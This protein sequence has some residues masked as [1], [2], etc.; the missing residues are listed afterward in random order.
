MPLSIHLARSL[1]GVLDEPALIIEESRTIAAN[2]AARTLLGRHIEGTDVRFAIRHPEAL[3]TI[4]A[5]ETADLE[6]VG[7]GSADR[8][9]LLTV[10]PIDSGMTVVRLIDQSAGRAAER[11]RD[12]RRELPGS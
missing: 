1:I 11:M 4:L 3:R 7:I 9:W 5:E 8:P 10:R 12:T 6:L 2:G